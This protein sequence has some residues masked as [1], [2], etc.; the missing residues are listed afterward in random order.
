[1]GSIVVPSIDEI[2]G[3]I[4]QSGITVPDFEIVSSS[5]TFSNPE[6]QILKA[7]KFL[8]FTYIGATSVGYK[9]NVST[10]EFS[11]TSYITA[12]NTL[13]YLVVK[14]TGS[15]TVDEFVYTDLV[16][17]TDLISNTIIIGNGNSSVKSSNV[18]IDSTLKD[19]ALSIPTGQVILQNIYK[20]S[21]IDAKL[22]KKVD[23]AS[24]L[25]ASELNSILI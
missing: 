24:N 1:M 8:N 5:G 18:S 17:G 11:F 23:I 16:S 22:N 15:Y 20:K 3:L 10:S 21:E 7:N 9:T 6:L 25:T 12:N 14:N 2:K 13:Y 19:S 4:A